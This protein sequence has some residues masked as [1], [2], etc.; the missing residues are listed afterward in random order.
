MILIG[1]PFTEVIR[2]NDNPHPG[3]PRMLQNCLSDSRGPVNQYNIIL[4]KLQS[5]YHVPHQLFLGAKKLLRELV[6]HP[7]VIIDLLIGRCAV[8]IKKTP[9]IH[10]G[11]VVQGRIIFRKHPVV[12]KVILPDQQASRDNLHSVNPVG[13]LIRK[14]NRI[15]IIGS[16]KND[17]PSLSVSGIRIVICRKRFLQ[18]IKRIRNRSNPLIRKKHI[19]PDDL[20]IQKSNVLC[21]VLDIFRCNHIRKYKSCIGSDISQYC[22]PVALCILHPAGCPSYTKIKIIDHFVSHILCY[23]FQCLSGEQHLHFSCFSVFLLSQKDISYNVSLDGFFHKKKRFTG[24]LMILKYGVSLGRG[25]AAD[26]ILQ[27]L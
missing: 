22:R 17:S 4:F 26:H 21:Q 23:D 7:S 3:L 1:T 27:L 15:K 9:Q 24:F 10:M 25:P 18:V 8:L 2:M 13:F 6:H 14:I 16:L 20:R 11:L 5:G 12:S 19:Q